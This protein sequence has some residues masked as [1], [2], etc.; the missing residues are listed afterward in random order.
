[1]L[2]HG[3]LAMMNSISVKK[4]ESLCHRRVCL[5]SFLAIPVS[6]AS[7]E[8]L[9]ELSVTNWAIKSYSPFNLAQAGK[10]DTL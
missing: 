3:A 5:R 10:T 2:K 9:F 6:V 7:R 1:M 8:C 4:I